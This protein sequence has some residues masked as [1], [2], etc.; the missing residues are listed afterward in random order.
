MDVT[1]E[2]KGLQEL[3]ARLQEI[4]ALAGQKLLRRVL[5]RVAKPM[6]ARAKS[7]AQA[8]ARSG[9]LARSIAIQSRREK[10]GQAARVVVTSKARDRTALYLHNS[11]YGRQ[12]KGIFYG[13]ML[14]QGHRVGTRG[15]GSLRRLDRRSDGGRA[16]G[17]QSVA[18]RP[19]WTPAVNASQ[20]PAISAFIAELRQAIDRVE[21]RRARTANPDA[22]V[23]V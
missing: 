3:E 4:G 10:P 6:A 14:D 7:N 13:W 22:V 5:R 2:I 15:T 23:P 1:V 16:T 12:R 17:L 19:W 9:A 20:G 11:A 18:P 21:R 8:V